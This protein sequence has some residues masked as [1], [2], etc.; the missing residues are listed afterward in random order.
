MFRKAITL[1]VCALAI[2]AAAFA[3]PKPKAV[4][5]AAPAPAAAPAKPAPIPSPVENF[6]ERNPSSVMAIFNL[7]GGKATLVDKDTDAVL[8]N[9]TSV[10]ANFTIFF[11]SCDAQGRACK[12]LQF[13]YP[14]D[15]PGPTFAQINA[16]NQTSALCRAYEDK[17]GRAHV[18]LSTLLFADDPYGHFR[19]QTQAWF[20]CI[21]DF[22][23]FLGDP[24]GYL[25]SAP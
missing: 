1:F 22:R 20:G 9:V 19:G 17:T 4:T 18:V 13:D 14:D 15:K 23:K 8:L 7:A 21:G 11:A 25:A 6:D 24:N 16:F 12:A 10:A 2:P 5:P 3:A